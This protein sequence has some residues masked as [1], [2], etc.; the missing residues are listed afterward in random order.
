MRRVLIT[1]GVLAIAALVGACGNADVAPTIGQAQAPVINGVAD[2]ASNDQVVLIETDLGN[3]MA[4]G[5]SGSL[6]AHRVVVTARHCV[7]Q[8]NGYDTG[9][10]FDP[11][12]MY[13]WLGAKPTS[14]DPDAIATKIIHDGSPTIVN[15]DLAIILLDR[16]VGTKLAPLR[17]NSA[18]RQGETVRVVGYGLTQLDKTPPNDLHARYRRD[19]LSV[20]TL[21]PYGSQIGSNEL[22]L[23]ESICEGDS[24][25]PVMDQATGALL[26]VTSRGGNGTSGGPY[27]Y[28]GCI[29]SNTVNIFERVDG[30]AK[31][32]TDAISSTGE[33]PWLE[34]QASPPPLPPGAPIGSAC[35]ANGDCAS[36]LSCVT[37]AGKQVC[38]QP[39]SAGPCPSGFTCIGYYCFAG[40]GTTPAD[41]AGTTPTGT[42]QA[43]LG[44]ACTASDACSSGL[45]ID[46]ASGSMCSQSCDASTPCPSGFACT[47][48]G[49]TL[50]CAPNESSSSSKGGCAFDPSTNGRV[51]AALAFAIAGLVAVG[52][53]RRRRS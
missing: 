21:G 43:G 5:C 25:G 22:A 12:K 18:P 50:V 28:S 36:G 14:F 2:D 20:L 30:Y 47:N 24:G 45:C 8:T 26:A 3:G 49:G 23:G 9:A 19:D 17:L 31:M 44:E 11:S 38:A 13:V 37:H 15:H 39:C 34:G 35:L 33:Q 16:H 6:V 27:P 52:A 53:A 32:I 51:P 42:G 29:G 46:T 48:A 4:A 7:S 10:D 1:T 41:D 40:S